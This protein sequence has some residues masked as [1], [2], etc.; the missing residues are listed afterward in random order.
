VRLIRRLRD[1]CD[2]ANATETFG[3][4]LRILRDTHR[5]KRNFMALL[6]KAG[7]GRTAAGQA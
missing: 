6:E 7:F 5:R 2:R 1:L 4:V 3:T